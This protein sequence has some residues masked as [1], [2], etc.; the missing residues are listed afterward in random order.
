MPIVSR[1]YFY[2]DFIRTTISWFGPL[3]YVS[4]RAIIGPPY[5]EPGAYL[6]AP[7]VWLLQ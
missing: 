4:F 6:S 7:T 5:R 1:E 2:V 3:V